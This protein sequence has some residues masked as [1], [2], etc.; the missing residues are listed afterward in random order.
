[1]GADDLRAVYRVQLNAGFTFDDA[2]AI[3]P[4]L[5]DLGVSH[6]YCSPILQAAPGSTHGY[7]VVD[8]GRLSD[9]LGG[10]EGFARLQAALRA[11]ALGLL[12]DVV[13][14]HMAVAGRRNAWW[15]DVLENGP[16]SRWASYFDIDW[17]PPEVKLRQT[18]LV[19]ILADHYGRVLEAGQL[20]LAR[21]DGSF[22]VRYH[23]HEVPV[24]P[25]TLDLLLGAAAEASGSAALADIAR[26]FGELPLASATDAESVAERH[27]SKEELRARLERLYADEPAVVQAIDEVVARINADPDAL[28]ALLERQ[29]YRLAFWRTAGQELDYRRFFDISSLV[30]LR[31]ERR[32]V[33]E[34]THRLIL[35]LVRSGQVQALRVDHPDGLRDPEAYLRALHADSDGAPLFVEKILAPAERLRASW[36]VEGTTG[37]DFLHRVNGLFVDPAGEGPLTDLYGR[38]TGEDTDWEQVAWQGKQ[39]V[40]R[41]VLAADME[42][43]AAAAVAVCERHRRYRDYTRRELRDALRETI[44]GLDVYRTYVR[45]TGATD[46]D[47]ARLGCAVDEARRRRPELDPNLLEFLCDVLLLRHDGAAE[48][49]LAMRFQQVSASVMAKGVEDTA[50]YRFARLLSLNEVGGHPGRFGTSVEEF[51]RRNAETQAHWPHALLTTTTHDTKRSEDARLRISLLSGMPERWGA[52]VWRWAEMNDRHRRDG[53]PDRH[54]EYV[55]YQTAVG[56]FPLSPERARQ[57]LEK[58]AR[59]AKRRTSWIDP[60]PVYEAAMHAFADAVLNDQ[61]FLADLAAFA[62]PVVEAGQTTALAG[63]LLKLT[64]PGVPDLYRGTELWDLSLVDPDNRRPMD[65]ELRRRLLGQLADADAATALA[66]IDDGGTKLWLI[67]RALAFRRRHAA[68]FDAPGAYEPLAAAGAAAAH[69]VAFLR[70]GEAAVIVPRLVPGLGGEWQDTTVALP[71]GSWVDAFTSAELEG[72]AVRVAEVLARFPVAL[73]G[74]R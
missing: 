34:D 9:D 22:V 69:V 37:Y 3:V 30:A 42:R 32:Q 1:M 13:P 49:E 63:T 68:A 14:N 8:H 25:R 16:A 48:A 73:L 57:Y 71:A 52:A 11:H 38:F 61:A 21:D 23:Q 24:S 43:L 20:A 74:R 67:H 28:D 26:G 51:H 56:A 41:T 31:I 18:V 19:P 45:R 64:S 12:L 55:L 50:F 5:R 58:A 27:R 36:P 53:L 59:E 29:N 72:G 54:L 39:D 10:A 35:E 70:G 66:T 40:M 60:D 44:A 65:W 2:A 62:A 46:E 7:D 17:N 15:W 4:Y 47:A 33:F 6:L